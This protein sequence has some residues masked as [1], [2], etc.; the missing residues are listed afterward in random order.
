M[1]ESEDTCVHTAN[2]EFYAQQVRAFLEAHGIACEFR[3]EALRMTHG[4]T[5][6]GLGEVRIHVRPEDVAR[7]R[8]L[9][10][11][12]EAGDLSLEQT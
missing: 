7:A 9:L 5:L 2:G 10:A 1:M 8:E 11:R 4:L 6:D 3:G 12:V